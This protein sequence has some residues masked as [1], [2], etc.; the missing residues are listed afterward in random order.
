MQEK[1]RCNWCLNPLAMSGED[2][3][4][5]NFVDTG[6]KYPDGSP[7][8]AVYCTDCLNDESR[9]KQPRSAIRKDTLDTISV[10]SLS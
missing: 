3:G 2:F 9:V 1:A 10:E 8:F 4:E 6:K 5:S 7:A